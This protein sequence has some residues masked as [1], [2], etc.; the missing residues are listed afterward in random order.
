MCDGKGP[1]VTIVIKRRQPPIGEY[2]ENSDI[3]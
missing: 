3:F 1:T 2:I